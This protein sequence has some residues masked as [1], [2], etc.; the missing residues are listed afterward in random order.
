MVDFLKIAT[1][2]T[3]KGILEVY[4]KF[5]VGKSSDLMIRGG[6]FYAI[7]LEDRGL[8][9]TDE[10][11][12]INLVDKEL[13]NFVK[14]NRHKY[15]DTLI[16]RYMWDAESGIIDIWHRYCQKQ[17]RDNYHSLDEELVFSNQEGCKE[18]YASKR[19]NYP[20]EPAPYDAWDKLVSLLYEPKERH[21]IEWLIGSVVTGASKT[22]EKFGVFYG[23]P[24]S[25]KGTILRLIQRLFKEY[26]TVF[27]AKALGSSTDS[28]ALE[29]FKNNPLVAI[30]FDGDLSHIE[31]NTRLNSLVSHETMMVNEKH[32]SL[33]KMLFIT[34]LF[35][36]TNK[37][38]KITDSKSGIIRRLIDITP[39]GEKIPRELYDRLVAEAREELSGIAWHCK[40]VFEENP[41]YYEDYIPTLMMSE[42]NDFYNF[43]LDSYTVFKKDDGTTLKAAWE[44]Y[45]TYCDDAKVPFPLSRRVFKSELK[46][47]FKNYEERTNKNGDWVRSYFSGFKTKSFLKDIVDPAVQETKIPKK[48][49]NLIEFL[50]QPSYFDSYCKNCLAQYATSNETP[51]KKWADVNTPLSLIDTSKLHYVKLNEPNHIVID[52]D[53]KDENGEKSFEK[54][55]EEASKWPKTYAELSKSGKGI[56]LHYI[57]DG[58]VNF[59]ERLYSKDIEIKVFT[60]DSSLRRKLTMCNAETINHLDDILPKRKENKM[61]NF[62]SLQNEKALRTFIVKNLNK[63]YHGATKPSIDFIY[64]GLEDAY[65]SGM[66]YDVSD[67]YD[68]ILSFAAQSTN[69]ADYCIK[70]VEKMRLKSDE[71][72]DGVDNDDQPIVFYDIEVFPN[73]LCVCW[74]KE[75]SKKKNILFNP[76]SLEIQKLM[77]YRLV[78]FNCRRYDN[79]I[80]YSRLLGYN[81]EDMFQLSQKIINGKSK[82]NNCFFQEAYNVSYTDIYDY[83]EK[84][85]SLKKWEIDL[86]IHH[87]EL[88]LPWDKP[89]PEELWPLV[90]EYC[91][92]DVDATE[93]TWNAT[94]EDFIARKILVMFANVL[95]PSIHSCVNDTD[96]QLTGR[97]IFRG[98]KTPQTQFLY[99]DLATGERSDGYKDPCHFPGYVYHFGTSVLLYN[100]KLNFKSTFQNYN[101]IVKPYSSKSTYKKGSFV[102]IDGKLYCNEEFNVVNEPFDPNDWTLVGDIIGE[103]G[104]V[105]ADPSMNSDAKTLDV[106]SMHPNSAIALQIFGPIYTKNFKDLVDLRAYVKAKDWDKAKSMLD[107]VISQ[108][109]DEVIA[110]GAGKGLAKSLKIAINAVYGLTSAKFEN[111]FK[112]PRNVD[113][114]VAKRGALF[115]CTLKRE[116]LEMGA[117]VIHLKTDSIKVVNPTKKIED[118][119]IKRGTEFGYTFELENHFER[120]CLVNDAVYIAKRALD[121]PEWV[122]ECEKAKQDGK[123]EPTR[124]TATG[125]QF[126]VPFVFKTCFSHEPIAFSDLCETKKVDTCLY[127]DMNENLLDDQIEIYQRLKE[128]RNESKMLADGDTL[129]KSKQKLLDD[130]EHMSDEELD[131]KLAS[132]HSYNF[133]GKIGLFSPIKQGCGGGLLV[134]ETVK[135]NGVVGFDSVTG[136]KGYRWLESEQVLK[137]HKEN[138]IDMEYYNN[139]VYSAIDTISK[140]GDYE[141]FVSDDN[142]A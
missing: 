21:K 66:R 23:A 136:T 60:G 92:N 130:Y 95:C 30:Q 138:D 79:H 117:H 115:M 116:L 106:R 59:L 91:G 48:K 38:V 26:Y 37:P 4:P 72:S 36:G 56:H 55:L 78:G 53:L 3:K 50:P 45:K 16:V 1:R 87:Q 83:S 124:W 105:W 140:F 17:L 137:E 54:N 110:M 103:G 122:D 41:L 129:T 126:S 97:I 132:Y 125:T 96:N 52:F 77:K 2:S 133:I 135:K 104:Y 120:V 119:I 99:T 127:L 8:W 46:A 47:Y 94:Q 32:K 100:D 40:E 67:M 6:D 73:L 101:D 43:M 98:N 14:E 68:D 65:N 89:V 7:W 134:R 5:I 118:Y 114:I 44:M 42:S 128:V 76:T 109:I 58:D 80:I 62:D 90:G 15:D 121:D 139:L 19:L 34:M 35:M 71:P 39:I 81:N 9:S 86:G 141:W 57:Y 75:G 11:D 84:K 108:L 123:P 27:D 22:L 82:L 107:G 20:L 131:L 12:V 25:G 24:G 113:N 13:D 49:K 29:A 63:E 61:V 64:K 51:R 85:Q 18:K 112:D 74:K 93:A 111:L 102:N 33:Y 10:Q 31:D 28:F 70:V 69:Q 142:V 88:G